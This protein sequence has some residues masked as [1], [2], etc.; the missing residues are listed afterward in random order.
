M[1]SANHKSTKKFV[2][3]A[4]VAIFGL[5]CSHANAALIRIGP[6]DF[7][8]QA[9]VITFSEQA[10]GTVNPTYLVSTVS[11]GSVTVS[12][13]GFFAG[14]TVTAGNPATLSDTTPTGPLA[15]DTSSNPAFI[16]DDG[17]NPT[18]PV[19]SGTPIFNGPIAVLFS[20][21]V[22]AVG[23]DG[24]FFNALGATS[25]EAFGTDG[26]SL[27][28]VSNTVEGIE[29]FGLADSS[30]ANAIQGISFYITGD[31]PAGF[32][33]DNLTF[34]SAREINVIPETGNMTAVGLLV[35]SALVIRKR[36]NRA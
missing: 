29:F 23:L 7:T 8:P 36:R 13:A 30:G 1:K 10:L 14:Q 4:S 21:P 25:I 31:E 12:F 34:G 26:A 32:A 20:T 11:L 35:A 18:S 3:A 6:G 9:S 5:A 24:G 17:A 15:L 22:A 27:G 19:L 2:Q 33:I 16:T 28:I